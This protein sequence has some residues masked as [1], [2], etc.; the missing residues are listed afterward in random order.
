M[1]ETLIL[2]WLC[3]LVMMNDNITDFWGWLAFLTMIGCVVK[4]TN[5]VMLSL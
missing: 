4:L 2:L 5:D 3:V 1:T